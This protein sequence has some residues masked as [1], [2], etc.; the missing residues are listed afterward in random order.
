MEAL[1]SFTERLGHF[2]KLL[3]CPPA[4]PTHLCLTSNLWDW[5]CVGLSGFNYS[6]Q[7]QPQGFGPQW[8]SLLWEENNFTA[9]LHSVLKE[10]GPTEEKQ[11][12]WISMVWEDFL[13]SQPTVRRVM[14]RDFPGPA[15][16]VQLPVLCC[17]SRDAQR[18]LRAWT[19]L[20]TVVQA[21]VSSK[22]MLC[23]VILSHVQ[24]SPSHPAR[25]SQG[26]LLNR[27]GSFF[28]CKCQLKAT[29]IKM[30]SLCNPPRQ[31]SFHRTGGKPRRMLLIAW[32]TIP[33]VDGPCLVLH[34][35]GHWEYQCFY[36]NCFKFF[37]LLFQKIRIPLPEK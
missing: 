15:C 37:L 10:G 24:F 6:K 1:G 21:Q 29:G 17:I 34:L 7:T 31:H 4:R 23:S 16:H 14:E 11:P 28:A 35:G 33:E 2:I 26:R 27:P 3:K 32:P 25:E 36:N 19:K 22:T 20:R 18:L 9:A 12:S 8:W 5:C 30:F 13:H